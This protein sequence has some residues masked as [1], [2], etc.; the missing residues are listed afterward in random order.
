LIGDFVRENKIDILNVAGPRASEWPKGYD[1]ASR[2]LDIFLM[3]F[4][5]RPVGGSGEDG[6]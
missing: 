3:P 2:A 1:Y 6:S 4:R 5:H